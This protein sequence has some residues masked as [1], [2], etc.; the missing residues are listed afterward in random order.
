[1]ACL[2]RTFEGT[3]LPAVI[4]KIVQ[5]KNGWVSNPGAEPLPLFQVSFAPIRGDFSGGF[6]KLIADMLQKEPSARPTSNDLYTLRLPDL[7][8]EGKKEEEEVAEEPRD[9]TKTK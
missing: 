4:H 6:R 9:L 2:E 7:I 3:N 8:L 5:V 1:M